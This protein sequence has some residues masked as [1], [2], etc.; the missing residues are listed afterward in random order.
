MEKMWQTLKSHPNYEIFNE[1]PF[2]IRKKSGKM[3]KPFTKQGYL[4]HT[5][6][7][8]QYYKH[9]LIANQFIP[10][11]DPANKTEI[12]HINRDRLDNHLENLRWI[13]HSDN[14]KNRTKSKTNVFNWVDELPDDAFELTTYGDHELEDIYY[15]IDADTFYFFNGNQYRPIN[16]CRTGWS[17]VLYIHDINGERFKLCVSKFKKL[18]NIA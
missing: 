1:Y 4:K 18:Y 2:D 9:V 3:L 5:I 16:V 14:L 7:G 8:K 13:S 10:N 12:D 6:D 15:S 11:D 17:N